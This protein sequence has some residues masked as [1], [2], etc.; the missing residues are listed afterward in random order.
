MVLALVQLAYQINNE[1]FP[2]YMKGPSE[3]NHKVLFL[4]SYD[5][6]YYTYKD[7]IRGLEEGLYSNGIEFD[8]S[9]MDTKIYG[10]DKDIE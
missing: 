5:P 8:I 1:V 3:V 7:Q 4:C 2:A 10:S 9:Y 6:M